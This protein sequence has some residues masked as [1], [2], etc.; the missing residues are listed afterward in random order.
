M[1]IL[2]L[3]VIGAKAFLMLDLQVL[4][5]IANTDQGNTGSILGHK[6]DDDP[7]NVSNNVWYY[8][9]NLQVG[10]SEQEI[11]VIVDTGSSDLWIAGPGCDRNRDLSW[12]QIEHHATDITYANERFL[13]EFR[14]SKLKCLDNGVFDPT[15]EATFKIINTMGP[16]D[17]SY[18]RGGEVQAY[19][20]QDVIKLGNYSLRDCIFGFATYADTPPVLGI[21]FS[22]N[23]VT[24]IHNDTGF[25]YP[26]FPLRLK[27]DGYIQSLSY[28]IYLGPNN[29]SQ[30]L[31]LFGAVDHG[32][33][34]GTL[35]RVKLV[36]I[37]D[38]YPIRRFDIILD[39][40]LGDNYVY[41]EQTY[42]LL[43][44]SSTLLRLPMGYVK[45][46]RK[47]FYP[48]R[49]L[50]RTSQDYYYE[51]D[52]K[53]LN[54]TELISFFFSG[55][56]IQVPVRDLVFEFFGCYLGVWPSSRSFQ[57]GTNFLRSAYV[58]FDLENKEIAM[59]Q[60]AASP[61]Q[62]TIEEIVS[63]V[64]LALEAPH[65]T[66]THLEKYIAYKK[67]DGWALTRHKLK[68]SKYS[69]STE[70]T[71]AVDLGSTVFQSY[72]TNSLLW[73]PFNGGN[74]RLAMDQILTQFL[75]W[76]TLLI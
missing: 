46:L 2:P 68:A 56:R 57:L 9:A 7:I 47:H 15:S 24:N 31:L 60:A 26:N 23:E 62:A 50:N 55:I 32:R 3:L 27:Q 8:M 21:G 65:Y 48:D 17:D 41:K 38:T 29:A 53:Y 59:A 70:G 19:W 40:I 33:Y 44:T 5:R 16:F 76:L 4:A 66:N 30:A 58:V 42:V 72:P 39:G 69:L 43:D 73:M 64:P 49:K 10:S 37:Y 45:K 75:I 18:S 52:C 54:L 67:H 28:S 63:L 13:E 36:N 74:T 51:I 34:D 22:E 11:G 35:Q 20:A 71:T 25:T 12:P 14:L 6:R 1:I 61:R